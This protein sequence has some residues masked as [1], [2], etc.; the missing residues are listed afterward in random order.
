MNSGEKG[1]IIGSGV[2]NDRPR[3]YDKDM[4]GRTSQVGFFSSQDTLLCLWDIRLPWS[5][6]PPFSVSHPFLHTLGVHISP[7]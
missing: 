7:A 5:P 4:R 3:P 2:R 1:P 6:K